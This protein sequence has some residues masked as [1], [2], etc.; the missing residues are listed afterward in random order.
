MRYPCEHWFELDRK[1]L[2]LG[3]CHIYK[4]IT[5]WTRSWTSNK[6]EYQWKERGINYRCTYKVWWLPVRLEASLMPV[7]SPFRCTTMSWT[8]I[9]ARRQECKSWCT[10][11]EQW[12]GT[13]HRWSSRWC[14]GA[15][16]QQISRRKLDYHYWVILVFP[17]NEWTW[18]F[19]VIPLFL[20]ME[21]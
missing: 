21:F 6:L 19:T 14:F 9:L 10:K 4:Q 12:L 20:W 1:R 5:V 18:L 17:R 11:Q 2:P 16:M 13:R 3:V 7:V 15:E 8:A